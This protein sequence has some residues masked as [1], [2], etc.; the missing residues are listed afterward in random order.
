MV[1][2]GDTLRRLKDPDD[3]D[4]IIIKNLESIDCR[5]SKLESVQSEREDAR[6]TV[7]K[8]TAF[9]TAMVTAIISVFGLIGTIAAAVNIVKSMP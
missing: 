1:I 2:N 6:D 4:R 5:L 8:S 3:K 7:S 9:K